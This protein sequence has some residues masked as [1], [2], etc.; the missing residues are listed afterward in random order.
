[1]P[2]DDVLER[3]RLGRAPS[4]QSTTPG[5]GG[6]SIQDGAS[7]PTWSG[8]R[9]WPRC[10]R[11]RSNLRRTALT[12]LVVGSL[13]FL[14]N[15]LA[16][17]LAGQATAS[18]WLET[19]LTFVVP[20]CVANV[21]LLL[22]SRRVEPTSDNGR[23]CPPRPTTRP[24]RSWARPGQL[25]GFLLAPANLRRTALVAL[26]V[27][28]CYLLVNQLPALLAGH[29]ATR[30]WGAIG[31]DYLMPFSVSNVGLAVAGRRPGHGPLPARPGA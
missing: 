30:V 5:T 11:Y 3:G 10:I 6:T 8:V 20:F 18:T 27:G 4:A 14:V 22:G 12:A 31:V 2:D 29:L 17:V 28:S 23:T 7:P 25:P 13:L 24:G 1:M 9:D 15:H 21:G 26:L 16:A 19:G